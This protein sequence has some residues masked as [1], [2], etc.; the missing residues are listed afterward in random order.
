V[1]ERSN[2]HATGG[3]GGGAPIRL[4]GSGLQALGGG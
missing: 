2:P 3:G 4:G 1:V